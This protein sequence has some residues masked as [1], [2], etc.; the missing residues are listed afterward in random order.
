MPFLGSCLSVSELSFHPIV[1]NTV[2]YRVSKLSE[3]SIIAE[4]LPKQPM[5]SKAHQNCI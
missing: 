3:Q 5:D 1:G 2:K 4:E